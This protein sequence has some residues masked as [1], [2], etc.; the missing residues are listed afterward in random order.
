MQA[1]MLHRYSNAFPDIDS[2]DISPEDKFE[3]FCKWQLNRGF[4]DIH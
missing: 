3:I 2:Y 1:R 4:P